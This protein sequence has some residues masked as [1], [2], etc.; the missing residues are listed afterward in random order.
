MKKGWVLSVFHG[1]WVTIKQTRD[2]QELTG[3]IEEDG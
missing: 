3:G 1:K 2:I